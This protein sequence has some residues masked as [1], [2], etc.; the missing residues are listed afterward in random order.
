MSEKQ[1]KI[2]LTN[3]VKSKQH[4]MDLKPILKIYKNI[5]KDWLPRY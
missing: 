2:A 5:K 1:N 3:R 4:E